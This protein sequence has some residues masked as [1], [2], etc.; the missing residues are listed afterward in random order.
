MHVV[1]LGTF[2]VSLYVYSFNPHNVLMGSSKYS[3]H[4]ID[5]A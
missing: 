3:P 5:A 4:L 1:V 2:S